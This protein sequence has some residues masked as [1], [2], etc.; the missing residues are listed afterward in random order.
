MPAPFQFCATANFVATSSYPRIAKLSFFI[1][2]EVA[3]D[4]N[5]Q[6][7]EVPSASKETGST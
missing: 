4:Q 3:K 6:V 1:Y 2:V 5:Q 7:P